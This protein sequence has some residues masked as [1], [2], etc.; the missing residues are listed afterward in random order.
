MK[1]RSGFLLHPSRKCFGSYPTLHESL[2]LG[3]S[4]PG[5]TKVA[6]LDEN[7]DS[8][9]V[10]LEPSEVEEV[11]A[12]VPREDVAGDRYADAYAQKIT[13]KH[14]VTPPLESWTPPATY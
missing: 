8:L 4:T 9:K 13:W 11:S 14:A 6:N 5:T 10:K 7:L 3:F 12:A 1:C 2:I